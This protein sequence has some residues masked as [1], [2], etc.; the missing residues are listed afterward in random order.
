[1]SKNLFCLSRQAITRKH[2][3]QTTAADLVP[4]HGGANACQQGCANFRLHLWALPKGALNE[5]ALVRRLLREDTLTGSTVI[6]HSSG[7]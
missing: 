7:P 4:E 1:M 5:M 6:S 2:Q 3:L